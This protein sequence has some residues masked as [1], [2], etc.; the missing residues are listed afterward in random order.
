MPLNFGGQKRSGAF[1]MVWL[2]ADTVKQPK[3]AV[4]KYKT[5]PALFAEASAD[6]DLGSTENTSQWNE[7]VLRTDSTHP[8]GT[9]CL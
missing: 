3:V 9:A 8:V 6:P 2:P 4:F 1:D 7:E 5:M